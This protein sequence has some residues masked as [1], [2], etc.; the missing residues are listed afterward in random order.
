MPVEQDLHV[1][2]RIDGDTGLAHVA[3]DARMVRVVAAVCGQVEGHRHALC[4]AGQRLA[5]EGVRLLCGGEPGVL[6]DGPG[7][8]GVHR[9]LRAAHEGFETGQRVGMRQPLQVG[10]GV[11]RLDGDAFGRDPVQRIELPARRGLRGRLGPGVECGRF[12][13]LHGVGHS[14]L[15]SRRRGAGVCRHG[16]RDRR[17]QVSRKTWLRFAT[18]RPNRPRGQGAQPRSSTPLYYP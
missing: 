12:V 18:G 6:A 2:D 17:F 8:H 16:H 13:M 15:L 7:P 9:R 10:S 5:I 3:G 11:Q 14:A 4:A 1:L